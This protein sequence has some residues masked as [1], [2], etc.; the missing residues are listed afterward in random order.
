MDALTPAVSAYI[1]YLKIE[2][3]YASNTIRSYLR[4]LGKFVSRLGE[5]GVSQWPALADEHIRAYMSWRHRNGM[6]GNSLQREL[7]SIRG[8]IRYLLRENIIAKDPST[9][10]HAPR[11]ASRL[12]ESLDADQAAR[13]L[14]FD[15]GE[16]P[17]WVRDYAM[18]ELLYSSGLRLAELTDITLA[19]FDLDAGLVRV[20]G[21][22]GKTRIVPVGKRA[23]AALRHW[24]KLRPALAALG[25]T[26]L[27]VSSRGTA[28]SRRTVQARLAFWGRRQGLEQKVYPHKL[29]H[30]FAS[31]LLE[32]SGNLRAVQE[33]LGHADISTTQ[34]YTHLD[35]QHLAKVYDQAHPRARKKTR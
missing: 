32:S 11:S 10:V 31:H 25:E 17:L 30:S 29:R 19:A 26:A 35:F 9:G 13:L 12:P 5:F 8:L 28:I 15:P 24:L 33:M 14:D 6:D 27:F 16:N 21:K 20:E 2:K 7:S 22:G 23:L 4:D 18:M 34:V 1:T 3:R